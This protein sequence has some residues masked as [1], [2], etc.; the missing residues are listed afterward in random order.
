MR[1][2]KHRK[3]MMD[4]RIMWRTKGTVLESVKIRLGISD[5]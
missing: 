5:L 4:Q 2:K 3:R 1:R